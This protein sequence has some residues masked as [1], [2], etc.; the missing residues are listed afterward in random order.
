MS[1]LIYIISFSISLFQ[2][3]DYWTTT[4]VLLKGGVEV[5]RFEKYLMLKFGVEAALLF[6]KGLAAIIVLIGAI[7]G[8]FNSNLTFA[9]LVG[10][11]LLYLW[12]VWNNWSVYNK[13]R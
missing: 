4:Q 6:T 10:L 7:M 9:A 8:W 2:V 12:V 5:N 1:I 11:F 13:M 3:I